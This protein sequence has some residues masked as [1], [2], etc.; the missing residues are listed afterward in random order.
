MIRPIYSKISAFRSPQWA[1][2]RPI[3]RSLGVEFE[4][5]ELGILTDEILDRIFENL[6]D[7][8]QLRGIGRSLDVKD[9]FVI[10]SQFLGDRQG[11]L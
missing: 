10:D 1:I 8:C 11:I 2:K 5:L 4:L 9:D 6:D 3:L 7:F